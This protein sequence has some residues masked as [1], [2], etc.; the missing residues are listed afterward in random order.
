VIRAA[1]LLLLAAVSGLAAGCARTGGAPGSPSPSPRPT[2]GPTATA[3]ATARATPQPTIAATTAPT[4]RPSG[5]IGTLELEATSCPG[6]V[7]LE[8]SAMS[9]AQF[10]HYTVLRSRSEEIAPDYPPVAPAVDWGETYATDPFV[11]A[12]VD[13]SVVPTD[14]VW[15][16]RAM[17]YDALDQPIAASAVRQA[18][19]LPVV[20]LGAAMI[21]PAADGA[22]RLAWDAFVGS[23]GCFSWYAVVASRTDASP[24]AID[25]SESVAT[26]SSRTTNELVTRA[27]VSGASYFVRVQAI[28]ATPMGEFVVAQ[29]EVATYSVP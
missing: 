23:P 1:A 25:G 11:T 22:T 6:G 9:D 7:V 8:W 27:L 2:V 16:Y 20:V 21:G 29:T 24:D 14:T 17:A 19:L 5:V 4:P 13:A 15:S 26:I 12:A 28:R 3:T 18:S 10:H